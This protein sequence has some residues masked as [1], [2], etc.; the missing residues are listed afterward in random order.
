MDHV[1]TIESAEWHES[2]GSSHDGQWLPCPTCGMR[3]GHVRRV[4]TE[5][6]PRGDENGDGRYSGTT[7]TIAYHNGSRRPAVRIDIEGECGHDWTLLVQQHKGALIL[8][9]RTIS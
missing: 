3:Y 2:G 6:D 7:E 1:F 8:H 9:A 4:A 5:I